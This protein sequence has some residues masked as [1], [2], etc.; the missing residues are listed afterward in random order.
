[1]LT[2]NSKRWPSNV[3]GAKSNWSMLIG[4]SNQ[5]IKI[6]QKKEKKKKIVWPLE[7]ESAWKWGPNFKSTQGEIQGGVWRHEVGTCRSSSLHVLIP[8]METG[9]INIFFFAGDPIPRDD[10]KGLN[11]S[12]T[13]KINDKKF[14]Y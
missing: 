1:M 9:N 14:V 7:A 4:S 12:K 10:K 2:N 5:I 13:C 6:P 8:T 3:L 11:G